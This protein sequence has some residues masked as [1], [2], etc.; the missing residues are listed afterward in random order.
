M[1]SVS[2]VKRVALLVTQDASIVLTQMLM[3]PLLPDLYSSHCTS[4]FL[5]VEALIT[6]PHMEMEIAALSSL[7]F[8]ENSNH[9]VTRWAIPR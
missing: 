7:Y 8:N 5:I 1:Y 3:L 6:M 2:R 9:V 4:D